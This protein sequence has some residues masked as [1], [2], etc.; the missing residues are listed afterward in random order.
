MALVA[1]I[2]GVNIPSGILQKL[3]NE[4][5]DDLSDSVRQWHV[6][7]PSAGCSIGSYVMEFTCAVTPAFYLVI[8]SGAHYV[9]F[10]PQTNLTLFW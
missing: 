9:T 10:S 6:K 1:C 7:V 3:R 8:L 5:D 4:R 2:F